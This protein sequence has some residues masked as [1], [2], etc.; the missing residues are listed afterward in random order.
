MDYENGYIVRRRNIETGEFE[1]LSPKLDYPRIGTVLWSPDRQWI[2]FLVRFDILNSLYVMKLD[3]TT[4]PPLGLGGYF[5]RGWSIDSNQLIYSVSGLNS[6]LFT[7]D[8]ANI[9]Q[10][11]LS[12]TLPTSSVLT[13]DAGG[14]WYYVEPLQLRTHWEIFRL[15]QAGKAHRLTYDNSVKWQLSWW[16]P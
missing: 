7:L 1:V 15:D 12:G 5:P 3:Q 4:E 9:Q 2:S 6:A 16:E 8:L 11:Q 10:N 13:Q 14:D